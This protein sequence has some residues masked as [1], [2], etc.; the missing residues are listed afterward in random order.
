MLS[1]KNLLSS[2]TEFEVD[3]K[4]S[5]PLSGRTSAIME[6]LYQTCDAGKSTS[7]TIG[8]R[9][10]KRPITSLS[11]I[12][13]LRTCFIKPAEL[14]SNTAR[15]STFSVIGAQAKRYFML[16]CRVQSK[17]TSFLILPRCHWSTFMVVYLLSTVLVSEPRRWTHDCFM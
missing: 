9:V 8:A 5:L 17:L 3:I 12:F 13:R 10:G 4:R 1:S 11:R 7:R 6:I 16:A 2:W 14:M 15:P